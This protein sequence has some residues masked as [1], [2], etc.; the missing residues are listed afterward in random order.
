MTRKVEKL[1]NLVE[2]NVNHSNLYPTRVIAKW[3]EIKELFI[4]QAELVEKNFELLVTARKNPEFKVILRDIQVNTDEG[5]VNMGNYILHFKLNVWAMKW[6]ISFNQAITTV[7]GRKKIIHGYHPHLS[8]GRPCLGDFRDEYNNMLE[9]F[10]IMDAVSKC[11]SFLEC[12]NRL[13]PYHD[14]AYYIKIEA[15]IPGT[16]DIMVWEGLTKAYTMFRV[17][18]IYVPG[19]D[20]LVLG[21]RDW[22]KFSKIIAS[23]IERYQ[24]SQQRAV[25]IF[26]RHARCFFYFINRKLSEFS[27]MIPNSELNKCGWFLAHN[28]RYYHIRDYPIYLDSETTRKLRAYD[29]VR[30]LD[31]YMERLHEILDLEMSFV[32]DLTKW[33]HRSLGLYS[34]T[35][36]GISIYQE[37]GDRIINEGFENQKGVHE[38]LVEA[39]YYI[40]RKYLEYL[41]LEKQRIENEIINFNEDGK[42]NNL[43]AQPLS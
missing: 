43:F 5:V 27:G 42:Q 32:D 16:D 3:E 29:R 25:A 31:T 18:D 33:E 12:Y 24:C 28:G 38:T 2:S 10:T 40:R 14:I 1:V 20:S 17:N 37:L 8:G 39:G 34:E 11:K 6:S 26:I 4:L 36:N 7:Y 13:N 21:S 41:N 19:M 9:N 22:G 23:I 15:E 30:Y 35:F